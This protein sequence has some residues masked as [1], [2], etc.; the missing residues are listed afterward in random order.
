LDEA[1]EERVGVCDL[2]LVEGV[3]LDTVCPE[4]G[5]WAFDEEAA[6]GEDGDLRAVE[7]VEVVVGGLN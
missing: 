2:V 1:G 3:V 7:V 4:E 5:V 6:A